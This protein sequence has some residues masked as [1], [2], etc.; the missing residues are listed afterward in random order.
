MIG[1]MINIVIKQKARY[2][3]NEYFSQIEGVVGFIT[4]KTDEKSIEDSLALSPSTIINTFAA[5]LYKYLEQSVNA[6][7][8]GGLVSVIYLQSVN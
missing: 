5:C 6:G 8:L 3:Y 4:G 2:A 7:L 1:K